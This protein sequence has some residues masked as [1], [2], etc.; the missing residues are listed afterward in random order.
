MYVASTIIS[1][2][3]PTLEI[4]PPLF[5]NEA[6]AKGALL[7]KIATPTYLCHSPCSYAKQEGQ[8]K[9]HCI[10]GSTNNIEGSL[11]ENLINLCF[12]YHFRQLYGSLCKQLFLFIV[13]QKVLSKQTKIK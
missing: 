12:C 4:T 11:A 1:K 9:Q 6:V 10:R 7:M 2:V 5:L 8:K 3:R 13:S